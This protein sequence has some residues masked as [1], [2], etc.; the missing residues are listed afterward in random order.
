MGWHTSRAPKVAKFAANNTMRLSVLG[1]NL[2]K[3]EEKP[4]KLN[5]LE[6]RNN[7]YYQ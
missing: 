1:G 3:I 7:P 5:S 4:R 2:T 6:A